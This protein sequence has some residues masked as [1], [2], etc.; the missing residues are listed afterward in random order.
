MFL[1]INSSYQSR[2]REIDKN[3]YVINSD[4]NTSHMW[5]GSKY[6]VSKVLSSPK[7][8]GIFCKALNLVKGDFVKLTKATA[9]S[10]A[11]LWW[12]V[13]CLGVPPP[14]HIW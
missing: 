11:S 4:H 14:L 3:K 5:V 10:D 8:C 9:N 7:Q 12:V 13:K 6:I 2:H 1:I